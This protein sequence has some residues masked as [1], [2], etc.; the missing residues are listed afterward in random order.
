MRSSA[1]AW[2]MHLVCIV[3][4]F[5]LPYPI[6]GTPTASRYGHDLNPSNPSMSLAPRLLRFIVG[7]GGSGPAFV[8]VGGVG[9]LDVVVDVGVLAGEVVVGQRCFAG[10]VVDVV[11]GG[12]LFV[13][14]VG[15]VGVRRGAF[16]L[17]GHC[18]PS[19]NVWM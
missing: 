3:T 19:N 15:V 5:V 16:V 6:V 7:R 10:G 14:L 11:E 1:T 18:H 13:G 8:A 2:L 4:P 9:E 17:L 12:V